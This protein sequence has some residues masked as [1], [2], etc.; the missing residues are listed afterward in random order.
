MKGLLYK[1]F[2]QNKKTLLLLLGIM[3]TMSSMLF[4]QNEDVDTSTLE[5]IL[6]LLGMMIYVINFFM[7]NLFQPNFMQT[8]DHKKWSNFI[9]SAP[10]GVE[11]IVYAKYVF[12]LMLTG[13]VTI[14]CFIIDGLSG[15]MSGTGMTGSGVYL[16]LFYLNL[17]LTAFDMPF[18]M[19]F[20]TNVGGIYRSVLFFGMLIVG[21][22]YALFGDLSMFGSWDGFCDKIYTMLKGEEMPD[23]LL[24]LSG[25]FPFVSIALYYMSYKLSCR[26][27]VKGVAH[28]E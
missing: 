4:M 11:K 24:L 1:E 10:D 21:V 6:P 18:M 5:M 26:L 25:V 28:Y 15:S 20:G 12:L 16:F 19:R 8:D 14:W 17:F 27:Y 9:I 23:W 2:V 22:V 13:L 3:L 7:L